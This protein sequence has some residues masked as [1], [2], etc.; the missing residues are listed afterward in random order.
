MDTRIGKTLQGG[1]YTLDDLLGQGGFGVTYRATHHY[2]D[3]IRVIKTLNPSLRQDPQY[4]ELERKFRDEAK[5]LESCEHE[6]IVRM[7]DFF[8]E[9]GVPYLVM[10][11]IPGQTLDRLIFPDHPLPEAI[12]IH[13]IRQI[14]AALQVVHGRGLLHRD[15]KPENIILRQGTDQVVLIDFGIARSF[16]LGQTQEHTNLVTVGYA[17]IEQ[18]L[19][20]AQRTPATDVYGLT[21][22]LYAL[23]TAQVPIASILR[24]RRPLPEP[25]QLMPHLSRATNQAILRGMALE[26]DQRSQTIADWL[27]LL[28]GTSAPASVPPQRYP[29]PSTAP[30]LAVSPQSPNIPLHPP[31]SSQFPT[32]PPAP[33]AP[34]APARKPASSTAA[35]VAVGAAAPPPH[36]VAPVTPVPPVVVPPG[37]PRSIDPKPNKS[38]GRGVLLVGF[39]TL[40]SVAIAAVAAV[41]YHNQEIASDPVEAEPEAVVIEELEPLP[42]VVEAEPEPEPELEESPEPEPEPIA[43]LPP[44]PSPEPPAPAENTATENS[45]GSIKPGTVP[46]IAPGTSQQEVVSYLGQPARTESNGNT[47]TAVYIPIPDQVSLAYIYNSNNQVQQ[48][49]A[50]FDQSVDTG[51]MEVALNGMLQ[52]QLNDE[53][54]EG[55]RQ[56]KRREA[57][58]YPIDL[59]GLQGVIERDGSD[60][61][62]VGVWAR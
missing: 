2:L 18:Y 54:R 41:L 3:E 11:Y 61:I 39:V 38:G 51:I 50:Y 13:Y 34:A 57:N 31:Q 36:S 35:T 5:R 29:N 24:E 48:T 17:P 10:D 4:P 8:I 42:P 6:N 25:R 49:E 62:F 59:N 14:G 20:R 27:A 30:T 52:Y 43:E 47:A 55:L 32:H 56:V 21:A 37:S 1:K 16:A 22:T 19:V 53:I 9:A 45:S 40:M 15:V 12:A 33:A 44:E 7:R 28:P 58:S 60:R 26:A 46:G 23:V